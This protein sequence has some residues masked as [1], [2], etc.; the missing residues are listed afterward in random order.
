MP[1]RQDA[2]SER[3]LKLLDL[4]R[5]I[6]SKPVMHAALGSKREEIDK[7]ILFKFDDALVHSVS[8]RQALTLGEADRDYP[9]MARAFEAAG[10]DHRN[11]LD[12]R[13][14]VSCFAKV[15]FGKKA[16]KP[17]KWDAVALCMLLEDYREVTRNRRKT[18]DSEACKLLMRSHKEKYGTY[19]PDALRK[20]IRRARDPKYNIYLRHPDM[21][22]PLLQEIRDSYER[23]GTPWDEELGKRVAEAVELVMKEITQ[24]KT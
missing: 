22:N 14:L 16:T 20:L 17:V 18:T 2:T 21:R 15:H 13:I 12:W 1:S 5:V 10:L 19:N 6:F 11:P 24:P 8:S 23:D 4:I 7:E 9:E 3:L